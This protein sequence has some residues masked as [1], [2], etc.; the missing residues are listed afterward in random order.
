[1]PL[2]MKDRLFQNPEGSLGF[3]VQLVGEAMITTCI[4]ARDSFYAC[5]DRMRLNETAIGESAQQ[6]GAILSVQYANEKSYE[7]YVGTFGHRRFEAHFA[8][9]AAPLRR[10]AFDHARRKLSFRR[11]VFQP[12][13]VTCERNSRK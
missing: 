8:S 3:G 10:V 7:P 12:H 13:R 9:F 1:M 11:L 5:R 4:L 6:N 2:R